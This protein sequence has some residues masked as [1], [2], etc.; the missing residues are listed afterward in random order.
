[1]M[2]RKQA[3]AVDMKKKLLSAMKELL[4]Q[5]MKIHCLQAWRWFIRLLGRYALKNKH[6]VNEMLEVL[7]LTFSDVDSQVQIASLVLC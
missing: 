6:L 4:G 7:K 5:G 3:L 1:M 2:L